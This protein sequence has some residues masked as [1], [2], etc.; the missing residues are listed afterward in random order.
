MP[1]SR[2]ADRQSRTHS[3]ASLTHQLT[4]ISGVCL[5]C[6]APSKYHLWRSI[7]HGLD[8]V[9]I[10]SRLFSGTEVAND[11]IH[12]TRHK[13]TEVIFALKNPP[14]WRLLVEVLFGLEPL[15]CSGQDSSI[16]EG[17]QE[18]LQLQV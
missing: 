18:V 8:D 10:V 15:S 5:L 16:F 1:R 13:R 4:G 17:E 12:A 2:P 11:G 14:L 6:P 3:D 7:R 9:R